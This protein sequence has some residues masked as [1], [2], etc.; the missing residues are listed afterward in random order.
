MSAGKYDIT[1]DQGSDFILTLVI[2]DGSAPRNLDGHFARGHLRAS[3]DTAQYWALDFTASSYD[4]NGTLVMKMADDVVANN[5]NTT[6]SE[7]NYFYDVGI[8]TANDATV[9]RILQGKAK[10]TREVTR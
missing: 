4:S 2:K 8:Y 10:V 5:G 3:M 9:G 7:G 6:L 1:I